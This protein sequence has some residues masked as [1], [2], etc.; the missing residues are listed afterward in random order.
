MDRVSAERLS[1]R[2]VVLASSAAFMTRVC[3]TEA[4]PPGVVGGF[5]SPALRSVLASTTTERLA[6]LDTL[7]FEQ[8]IR[9]LQASMERGAFRAQELVAWY[10]DR[11]ARFDVGAIRSIVALNARAVEIAEAR[12]RERQQ[13][14]SRGL[15]H[16][17]P[18]VLKDNI[19]TAAPLPTT[20]GAAALA[21]A[22]CAHNAFLVRRL[23]EHGAILL[24]KANMS[25]WA[26]WMSWTA[27]PGYSF[28]GGQTRNPYGTWLDPSGSSTGCAVAVSANFAAFAIGT[29]TRGSIIA[30]AGA[31]GVAGMHPSLGLVSRDRVI[32]IFDQMDTPGPICRTVDDLAIVLTALADTVDQSDPLSSTAGSLIGTTFTVDDDQTTLDGRR[33]G[34][35]IPDGADMDAYAEALEISEAI[36]S[37]QHAGATIVPVVVPFGYDAPTREA[38]ANAGMRHGV[39]AF[40]ADARNAPES[41]AAIIAFNQANTPLYAPYGQERLIAAETSPMSYDDAVHLAIE[42]RV[43]AQATLDRAFASGSLDAI[44]SPE[45]ALVTMYALAG[46]PTVSVPG[47]FLRASGQPLGLALTARYLE[48]A[49][50]LRLAAAIERVSPARVPPPVG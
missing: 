36:T 23:V 7:A 42:N 28:I 5:E 14:V 26:N 44:L 20:A 49:M 3:G 1:R 45:N 9:E 35:A 18:F 25:E 10:L 12:D 32:P 48:D 15:L 37:L 8:P 39:N 22:A 27:P 34:L 16:G 33:I 2:S 6:E 43:T 50:L 47:G 40:L 46:Y 13:G 31:N 29:E 4:A 21:R 24:G 41:L 17:V 11:I 38:A 30:P 19:G